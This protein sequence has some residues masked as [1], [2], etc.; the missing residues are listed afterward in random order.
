MIHTLSSPAKINTFLKVIGKRDDGYHLLQSHFALLDLSDTIKVEESQYY[1]TIT[2][3]SHI[4]S[5]ICD[6]VYKFFKK[7]NSNLPPLR[8]TITKNI[9]I[10]AGLGGGSSNAAS[11]AKFINSHYQFNLTSEDLISA[12]APIGADIPFFIS[13]KNAIVEG[14]GEKIT[15]ITFNLELPILVVNPGI[16]LSTKDVFSKP[17]SSFSE[18]TVEHGL[19]R[20]QIFDGSNDLQNNAI[21]LAPQISELLSKLKTLDGAKAARMS[22]SGATCFAIFTDEQS[23]TSAYDQ[24]SKQFSFCF[25]QILEI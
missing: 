14:I 2:I 23:L 9:P 4:N 19:L 25:K 12:F 3:G 8:V 10:A 20:Q 6:K 16:A 18:S 24:L 15:P 17:L 22:G 5:N 13:G 1:E 11:L 21:S 7:L